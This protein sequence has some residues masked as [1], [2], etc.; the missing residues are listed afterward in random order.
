MKD[1]RFTKKAFGEWLLSL[2]ANFTINNGSGRKCMGHH[3][4][5]MKGIST[6]ENHSLDMLENLSGGWFTDWFY[7]SSLTKDTVTELYDK[8]KRYTKKSY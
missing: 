6:Q 8:F 3:F 2:P 4:V 5:T 7:H 1:K